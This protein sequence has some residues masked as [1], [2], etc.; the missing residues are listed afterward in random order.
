MPYLGAATVLMHLIISALGDEEDMFV[1]Q[2]MNL[3]AERSYFFLM[4]S[5]QMHP[6]NHR[7]G[8]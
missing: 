3:N 4:D 1:C 8:T 6:I 2:F 7:L 5:V